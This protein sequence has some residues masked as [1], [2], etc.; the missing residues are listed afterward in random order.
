MRHDAGKR[1]LPIRQFASFLPGSGVGGTGEH[2]G[3][4]VPRFQPDCFE[5]Y[6]TTVAR[7]GSQKLP[8]GHSFQDWGVTYDEIEAY[9]T[10]T[11]RTLGVSG[12]AGNI[13]GQK[14]RRRQR[15]R[16]L[17]QR[18]VSE[19][20][21]EEPLFRLVA[22][23]GRV[24]PRVSPLSE[25]DRDQQ[26]ALQESRWRFAGRLRLLRFL[27][28]PA[29][30]DCRQ[31]A[32]FQY[33]SAPRPGAEGRLAAHRRDGSAHPSRRL[34]SGSKSARGHVCRRS[35]GRDLFSPPTSSSSR[36]TP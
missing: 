15:L 25:S 19:S 16:W 17:A 11:E 29:V 22:G 13:R 30:H 3:A 4:Q 32:A 31:G 36:P 1:S 34:A 18:G 10:R 9:Y 12:K 33:V 14:N 23:A 20:A 2:W 21:A 26:S 8:E 24:I 5:L 7:Y 6:S 35:R 28:T 27:R